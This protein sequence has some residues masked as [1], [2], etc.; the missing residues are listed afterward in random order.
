M[1]ELLE[2]PVRD[3]GVIV[4]LDVQQLDV[5]SRNESERRIEVRP[6]ALVLEQ[7]LP[8]VIRI[9]HRETG[10]R[11]VTVKVVPCRE[12]SPRPHPQVLVAV[13]PRR[14]IREVQTAHRAAA[15]SER[16]AGGCNRTHPR[17]LPDVL[18]HA[19]YAHGHTLRYDIR[20]VVR[21]DDEPADARLADLAAHFSAR[22]DRYF[23]TID[24]TDAPAEERDDVLL[25]AEPECK[26]VGTLEKE[27]AL[28][29]KEQWKARQVRAARVDFRLRKVGVDGE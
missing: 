26:R 23:D 9:A 6:D 22:D 28:L 29:R 19:S 25:E 10:R 7:T 27:R 15:A 8:R 21:A 13:E 16:I 20:F 4:H 3:A 17:F 24:E 14:R 18:L 1:R 12:Q 2:R 11:S 5:R